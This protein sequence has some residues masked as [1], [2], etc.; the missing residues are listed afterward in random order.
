MKRLL[1][2]LSATAVVVALF[3]STPVGH[4]VASAV[5]AFAKKAGYAEK[6]GNAAALNGIKASKVPR[7]GQLVPLGT[8]GRFP[9]SVA[10]GGPAGPQGPKGDKGERGPTG[11]KGDTGPRGP[12]GPTG[13]QG[14][15]GPLGPAGPR[16]TS[17]WEYMTLGIDIAPDR[18]AT[19]RVDCSNGKRAFG[20][21]VSSVGTA[22]V[23]THIYESAPAGAAGRPEATGW[24]VGVYHNTTRTVRFYAWVICAFVTS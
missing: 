21:G 11:P 15:P 13:Q 7:A 16:G 18:F 2:T 5:P 3:G 6:A 24:K 22:P 4:A 19:W 14:P 20:G 1:I 8:D 12:A 10:L 17:G 23:V 9:A